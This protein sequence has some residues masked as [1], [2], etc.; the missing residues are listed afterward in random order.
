[1]NDKLSLR[2]GNRARTIF[3]ICNYLF[4]VIVMAI[5]LI[6]IIKVFV[7]SIDPTAA[8]GIRL[9]PQTV[10]LSAYKQILS[11]EAFYRPLMVS[12][13][14]TVLGTATGLLITT[15][16]AYV[17]IQKDMPGRKLFVNLIMLTMLFSGGLIP[18]YLTVKSVGLIGSIWSVILQ[19]SLSAYNMV[20]MKSFFESLPP[21]LFEAAEVD[22]CT[23]IGIFF[24]IVLPLS[25]PALASIGLFI[26]VTMWNDFFFSR[27]YITDPA[28]QN[29]QLK[30]REMIIEESVMSLSVGSM[31][32]ETLK[33]AVVFVVI[34]PF[35]VIYPF[36]QKYFVKGV[37]LG[38]VKG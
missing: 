1:M 16:G 6:P 3:I 34:A 8:Y 29:F 38:A 4:F 26:G 25:K 15:M 35:M 5:M 28:W 30:V 19:L 22:G 31:P 33:S 13:L 24:K 23:P 17:I 2:P 11:N 20:L 32:A 14:I 12:A 27:I 37:T 36:L 18:T 9:W 7:D 21:S 10:S